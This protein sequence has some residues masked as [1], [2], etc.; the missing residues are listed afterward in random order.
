MPLEANRRLRV[1]P[2]EPRLLLATIQPSPISETEVYSFECVAKA[3]PDEWYTG[4]FDAEGNY[5]P[6]PY[7][8]I[9]EQPDGVAGREKVNQDYVWGMTK[10]NGLVYFSSSGNVL[11]LASLGLAGAPGARVTT[12]HAEEGAQSQYP[13]G[14]SEDLM[15]YLG[16]W[17]PPEMHVYDTATDTYRNI[18]PDDDL[19]DS[20]LGL[21]SAG[22]ANG[23][24]LFAGPDLTYQ[25]MNLFAFNAETQAYLGS[26]H[27]AQY[28]DIR[29]W[30]TVGDRLYGGVAVTYSTTGEGAVLMWTGSVRNPFSLTAIVRLD[31]NAANLAV[32]DNR[33][34]V[35]TWPMSEGSLMG[36]L[37][38]QSTATPGIWM[39]PEFTTDGRI[40]AGAWSKVWEITDY[41]VDPVIAQSEGAGAMCS[42]DGYLYWGTM[43][44]P[45]T[46][47]LAILDAYPDYSADMRT[48]MMQSNRSAAVFRCNDFDTDSPHVELLYGDSQLYT[49]IP[50][51]DMSLPGDWVLKDNNTGKALFGEAGFDNEANCYIWS[52]TVYN[53]RLYVG[54]LDRN[55]LMASDSYV[56]YG[57]DAAAIEA[58][59][60]EMWMGADLW[61]L[62]PD[63]ESGDPVRPFVV[64]KTG[65]GNPLNHGVRNMV[66]V[67]NSLFLGTANCSNLLTANDNATRYPGLSL[68][69]GGWEVVRVDIGASSGSI[70]FT[71]SGATVSEGITSD[72]LVG[73][74]AVTNPEVGNSY[75]FTLIDNAAGRFKISGNQIIALVNTPS[76]TPTPGPP[77][78]ANY[79]DY[80]TMSSHGIV[81]R[82]S[83]ASGTITNQ[84]FT[85]TVTDAAE[86]PTWIGL[87]GLWVY[88]S[89]ATGTP[90]GNVTYLDQDAGDAVTLSLTND[91]GGRFKLVGGQLQVNDG[92]LLDYETATTQ[93]V[94][95]RA[96][97]TQGLYRE[98][99]FKIYL[100]NVNEAP[101]AIAL[102]AFTVEEGCPTGFLVGTLSTTDP[103][104]SDTFTYALVD[105][106]G[107]RFQM[108]GNE[109]Q[110]ANGTLLDYDQA[111]N[112][113]VT[114]RVADAGGLSFTQSFVIN[115]NEAGTPTLVSMD[116]Q[117]GA[118]QR[119][120]VR[121]VDLV[122]ASPGELATLVADNR[123][124]LRRYKLTGSGGT[125][126][127]LSG[128][129]TAID[130]QLHFDFGSAGLGV[131]GYYEI[132]LDLNDD[133][134]FEA[135][136]HFYRLQGDVNGDRTVDAIDRTIVVGAIG[137][138]GE[139][140]E[141]DVNGDG[142]VNRRDRNL[143]YRA[144][145]T[146]SSD[147]P[148]DD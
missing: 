110:V 101:T 122:F 74:L 88:E 13:V 46:G 17:R 134:S 11:T 56:Q 35:G 95:L 145:G 8:A 86:R 97:D 42:F 44:V 41:E 119:S 135:V 66:V 20:T 2:L 121:Y 23:V 116:V 118:T 67:N 138:T 136:R 80:E 126:V 109:L 120:F 55:T 85:I 28:N 38:Y 113:T 84:V 96:T 72:T 21:R 108:V 37:G 33:L 53:D 146:L 128:K 26:K 78:Q 76:S 92:T 62:F 60:T 24:V 1:E 124:Q 99:S 90:I 59:R 70:P 61:C 47:A 51:T 77:I 5:V 39:S 105:S 111:P 12:V 125:A 148:L 27:M 7:Y 82:V 31:L 32:H 52:M 36:Y 94:T 75:T 98:T 93:T 58:T 54:T 127:S 112:H 89:S 132:L 6:G 49:F 65:V 63:T 143:V 107:G 114:V 133:G 139:N 115:V 147:L 140:L 130:N 16:D 4:T 141:A 91:A 22:A 19:L 129:L 81:V 9:G 34:F 64:D 144:T 18:T 57:G 45:G 25:G 117:H 104:V 100:I 48:M 79:C 71:L 29:N 43:Q 131:N 40:R 69:A 50:P 142:V 15:A 73:T 14:V 102:S 103:D 83:D 123:V 106:A 137:Q 68:K 3:Q 10:V 87:S 30:V